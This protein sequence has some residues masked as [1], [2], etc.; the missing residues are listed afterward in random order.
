MYLYYVWDKQE[1]GFPVENL[2][3]LA[4]CQCLG[5]DINVTTGMAIL[6]THNISLHLHTMHLL[7]TLIIIEYIGQPGH[8]RLEY[9]FYTFDGV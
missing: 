9:T 8:F 5:E 2:I 6:H 1:K 3:G 4:P 7:S